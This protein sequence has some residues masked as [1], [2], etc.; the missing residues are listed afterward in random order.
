VFQFAGS[1]VLMGCFVVQLSPFEIAPWYCWKV[2]RTV[3]KD[4]WRSSTWGSPP[5]Q[6]VNHL[7]RGPRSG[8]SGPDFY[9]FPT[10]LAQDPQQWMPHLCTFNLFSTNFLTLNPHSHCVRVPNNYTNHLT[11]FKTNSFYS[12]ITFIS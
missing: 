11:C 9:F 1:L 2:R 8:L 12:C 10:F 4:E 3:N 5:P 6:C 7:H